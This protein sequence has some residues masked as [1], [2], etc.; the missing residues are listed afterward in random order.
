LSLIGKLFPT[1][2][3]NHSELLNTASF[4]TQQDIGGDRT[5]YINDAELRNAPN[6]TSWRRGFGVP[7]L[8]TE[9]ILFMKTDK[10]PTQRQLYPI[11]E[12][13]KREGDP[14]HAPAFM[15]LLVDPGQSRIPG[16]TLDYSRRNYG[17]NI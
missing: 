11:A 4:I 13:G 14:T 7:V 9:A 5:D 3:P 15:R 17:A 6:T 12:L 1:T 8:L 2:D 10:Q 16:D